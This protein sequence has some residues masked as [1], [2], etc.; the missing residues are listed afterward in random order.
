MQKVYK[1]NAKS[2]NLKENTFSFLLRKKNIW[3][4]K[5]R[6]KIIIFAS[7]SMAIRQTTGAIPEIGFLSSIITKT[8][9]A[10]GLTTRKLIDFHY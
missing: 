2:I 7:V 9:F 6:S 5:K 4:P 8:K 10:L 1:E 3:S